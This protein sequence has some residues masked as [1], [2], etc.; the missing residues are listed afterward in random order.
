M[1]ELFEDDEKI[2][3]S[4]DEAVEVESEDAWHKEDKIEHA[5]DAR[6]RLEDLLDERKLREELDDYFFSEEQ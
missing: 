1:T 2:V 6:R 3:V 5:S 4:E